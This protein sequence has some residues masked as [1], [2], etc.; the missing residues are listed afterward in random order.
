[1]MEAPPEQSVFN[2]RT[3]I[4]VDDCDNIISPLLVEGQ[5][6]GGIAQGIAQALY[7]GVA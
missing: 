6:H 1:M 7:E 4:A 3:V 5:I 2:Q